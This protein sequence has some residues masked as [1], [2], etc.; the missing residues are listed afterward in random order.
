MKRIFC[1]L[2]PALLAAPI[3]LHA[4]DAAT[5]ARL[6]KLSGQIDDLLA[7]NAALQKRVT[8]LTAEVDS[9][10]QAQSEP[11]TNYASLDDVN[12]L[13]QQLQDVDK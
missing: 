11:N 7:A 3:A 6:D 4:Q 13:A 1:F 12:R 10:Q 9:L 8:D 5:Q 2:I